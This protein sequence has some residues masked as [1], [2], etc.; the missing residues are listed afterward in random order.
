MQKREVTALMGAKNYWQAS[1]LLYERLGKRT[2]KRAG[3]VYSLAG[4]DSKTM[5]IHLTSITGIH[6]GGACCKR[7]LLPLDQA[8][9]CISGNF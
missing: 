6:G 8:I 2:W 9:D 3:E 1:S 5:M 4:L 7:V